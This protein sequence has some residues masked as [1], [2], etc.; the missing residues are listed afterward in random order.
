VAVNRL[1]AFI[2]EVTSL[3]DEGVLS[4][5]EGQPLIDEAAAIIWQIEMGLYTGVRYESYLSM[6]GNAELYLPA[7]NR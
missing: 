2:N 6:F 3:I 1:N 5:E 4:P 7:L